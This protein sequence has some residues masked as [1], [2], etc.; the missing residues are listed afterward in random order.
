MIFPL[1]S[2]KSFLRLYPFTFKIFIIIGIGSLIISG[3]VS[4]ILMNKLFDKTSHLYIVTQ[5][6]DSQIRNSLLYI[7]VMI[8]GLY[9]FTFSAIV[10]GFMILNKNIKQLTNGNEHDL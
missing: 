10:M 7:M 5:L 4:I 8:N 6:S 2:E 1:K 3:Y 9:V